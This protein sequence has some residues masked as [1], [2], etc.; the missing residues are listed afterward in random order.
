[1]RVMK[2]REKEKA[3]M[4]KKEE[5]GKKK[6]GR[7]AERAEVDQ[8]TEVKSI[9]EETGVILMKERIEVGGKI[10]MIGVGLGKEVTEERKE[11]V[12]VRDLEVETGKVLMRIIMRKKE[13]LGNLD[14]TEMALA[15][16]H[17]SQSAED[18]PGQSLQTVSVSI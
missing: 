16:D 12:K 13:S 7:K 3:M 4:G 10:E 5:E 17:P 6:R 9:D 1:M 2:E 18:K 15:R 11:I 8:M 14:V